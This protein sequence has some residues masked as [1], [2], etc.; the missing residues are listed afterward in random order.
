MPKTLYSFVM[1]DALFE[2]YHKFMNPKEYGGEF[3][4][5]IVKKL[6]SYHIYPFLFNK[7]QY[8]RLNL[9]I[10][11]NLKSQFQHTSWKNVELTTLANET[12]FKCILSKDKNIFPYININC[13]K[14]KTSLTGTFFSLESR[15]KALAHIERLC[16]DARTITIHDKYLSVDEA[17]KICGLLPARKGLT[18]R[19]HNRNISNTTYIFTNIN[20]VFC[21]HCKDW[22]VEP[23]DLLVNSH[24]DRYMIIDDNLA[25]I[26]T[27]GFSNLFSDPKDITYI[28]GSVDSNPLMR[29]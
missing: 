23:T 16:K 8:E 19:I 5:D 17:Q 6:L 25:V 2:E 29:K 18:I 13:D 24:H 20:T 7:R 27:S 4:K 21:N 28:V 12:V 14:V 22:T 26:L 10:P 15:E 3:D 11:N 1:E 9:D